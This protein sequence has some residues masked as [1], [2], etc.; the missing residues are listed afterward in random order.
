MDSIVRYYLWG[1]VILALL[2]LAISSNFLYWF[3]NRIS[4]SVY[5]PTLYNFAKGGP[6]L[7]GLLIHCA[8]FGVII[9]AVIDYVYTQLNCTDSVDDTKIIL[10]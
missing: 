4:T 8:I 7:L 10:E 2:F 9:F 5:G 3:T 6:T 1:S